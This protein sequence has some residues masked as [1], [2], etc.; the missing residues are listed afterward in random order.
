MAVRNIGAGPRMIGKEKFDLIKATTQD[1]SAK[2]GLG[3]R[4]Q[5]PKTKAKVAKAEA[6]LAVAKK[7]YA[8]A[9]QSRRGPQAT[10]KVHPK[11][12]AP[13]HREPLDERDKFAERREDE[14]DTG[15]EGEGGA[16]QGGEGE[17]APEVQGYSTEQVRVLLKEAPGRT[18]D[19][20]DMEQARPDGLRKGVLKLLFAAESAKGDDGDRVLLKAIGEALQ[21]LG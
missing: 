11:P 8:D 6:A 7:A 14:Q 15:A 10:L 18:L 16:E 13:S 21:K 5:S 19:V 9:P 3:P 17:G 1:R 2:M 4:M 12:M 20:F